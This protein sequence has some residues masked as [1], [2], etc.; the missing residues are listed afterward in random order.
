MKSSISSALINASKTKYS[1]GV[2]NNANINP[3]TLFCIKISN[4]P[5]NNETITIL[6]NLK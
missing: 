4:D 1:T 2:I 3:K 6:K 5:S